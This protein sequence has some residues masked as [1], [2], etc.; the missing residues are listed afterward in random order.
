MMKKACVILD[1]RLQ[2][3]GFSY[4]F[5][6]NIHDEWQIEVRPED[7][8]E[9][10]KMAVQAIRDAGDALGFKCPLDGEYKIGNNWKETH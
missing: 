5:V 10:G 2:E 3:T 6:L 7:A 1:K 9:I 8:E 4:H